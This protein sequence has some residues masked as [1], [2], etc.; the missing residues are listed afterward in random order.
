MADQSAEEFFANLPGRVDPAKA[1][2]INH[3]YAFDITGAGQ[4][5][6]DVGDAGVTVSE[7]LQDADATISTSDEVFMKLVDGSQNPTAAYMSGKLKLR[8]NI[9]AAMK[10]QKLF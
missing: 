5:T 10:L 1:A 7:G 9:G 3:T 4:W 6:V 8:G 2:E